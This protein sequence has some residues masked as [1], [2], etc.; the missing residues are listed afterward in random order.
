MAN[1]NKSWWDKRKCFSF[2][3]SAD[4]WEIREFEYMQL[5]FHHFPITRNVKIHRPIH[6]G[7]FVYMCC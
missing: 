2:D 6:L 5:I 7:T 3:I 1:R 4:W